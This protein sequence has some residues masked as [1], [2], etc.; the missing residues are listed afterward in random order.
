MSMHWGLLSGRWHL[1]CPPPSPPAPQHSLHT[2][3]LLVLT[4]AWMKCERCTPKTKWKILGCLCIFSVCPRLVQCS[5]FSVYQVVCSDQQR[6][7]LP[8]ETSV[9]EPIA[10]L[11]RL[12]FKNNLECWFSNF[13]KPLCYNEIKI[14]ARIMSECW[15]AEPKARLPALRYF[16]IKS[17]MGLPLVLPNIR[18]LI[19]P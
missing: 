6:P 19:W 16:H 12:A 15:Y 3:T 18:S 5:I 2:G 17:P 1:G 4:L 9:V 10:S 11:V 13:L 8:P 7:E 14:S